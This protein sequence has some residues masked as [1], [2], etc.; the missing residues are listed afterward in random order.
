M[1]SSS[2]STPFLIG[3]FFFLLAYYFFV[4]RKYNT[5]GFRLFSL[6]FFT[7][8][9]AT[10]WWYSSDRD[11]KSIQQTGV[12]TEAMVLKKTPESLQVRFTDQSGHVI[13][14][15]QK[16]GISV[17]EFAA[18]TEGQPAPILY[19]PRS[20][21]FYLTSSYQR[22]RRDNIYLLVFPAVL[23]LIGS[24]CWFFLRKYRVHAREGSIYE[25][26][27]D[28]TG[29]VVLDDAASP[30]S[31]GLRNYSTIGKLFELFRR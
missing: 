20:K 24:G 10:Y 17:E 18:V 9:A 26:V 23:F 25:Y 27:T 12:A 16:G 3:Y 11:L 28:E 1:Q 6:F 19:T 7:A 8:V 2:V 4:L 22:Q 14:R 31:R 15:T 21:T 30:L 13:E 5:L 29:K